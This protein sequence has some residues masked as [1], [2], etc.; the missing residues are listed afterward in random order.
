MT[1][2]QLP[3]CDNLKRFLSKPRPLWI[4][5]KWEAS[6]SGRT[7][8]SRDPSTGEVFA[9]FAEGDAEDI[10]L[11][12]ASGRRAFDSGWPEMPP[13][14]RGRLLNRI[15]DLIEENAEEFAQL[16]SLDGGKPVNLA[17]Q[18]DV[19]ISV[20]HFRY[21]AG[22]ADKITGETVPVSLPGHLNYTVREP[23]GVVGQII[24]WNFPLMFASTH[25]APALAAGC[26]IVL[27]PAE[28]TSLSALRMGEILQEAGL[29][30]GVVNIVPGLGKT[31][32]AA[33]AAHPDVDKIAFTGS[34]DVGRSIIKAAAGNIKKVSLELGGLA[35][36][37]VLPDADLDAVAD[38]SANAIF[39]HQGQ[40]CCAGARLLV[41]RSIQDELVSEIKKR[42][43][44]IKVGPGLR[45]DTEMGPLVS[46]G[47][48]DR[49]NGYIKAGVEQGAKVVT[50]GGRP[51]G[52]DRGYFLEPTIFVDVEADMTIAQE[53]IFGPV[54]TVIGWENIDEMIQKANGTTY[55]L[56]AGVWTRDVKNA[57]QIAARLRAGTVWINC[58]N[59]FDPASPFGGYRQSGWGR[60]N[61]RLG[62]ELYTEV[63]SVWVNM[64]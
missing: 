1:A 27:K 15:A 56:T 7:L 35:P 22:W 64:N 20:S 13:N 57:H 48:L 63:K 32:G 11:A 33:L 50:G 37:V 17:H 58:W 38:A 14:E 55:G 51:A 2:D 3:V 44:A 5:G 45:P 10:D 43:M 41:H 31:A 36:N 59:A 46:Q 54:L 9:S 42:A 24:P 19:P 49:V 23:V 26:C 60:E 28:L 16:D 6:K 52:L 21:C 30:D 53:E 29:P 25:L 61:G 18:V 62:V 4:D 47:Q 12:V 39:F 40:A 8:E 34:T